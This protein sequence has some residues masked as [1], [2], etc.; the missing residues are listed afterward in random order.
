MD[1]RNLIDSIVADLHDNEKWMPTE[2]AVSEASII[3]KLNE[4]DNLEQKDKNGR[5]LLVNAVCYE[6]K[7]VVKYLLSKNVDVN[8]HVDRGFTAL[9]LAAETG[10]F[11]IAELLLKNGAEVDS[12]DM[13][14]ATPLMRCKHSAPLSIFRLLASYGADPQIKNFHGICALDIFGAYPQIIEIFKR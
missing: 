9:H 1:T 11:D 5:T 8:V 13:F 14:G 4:I 7:N 10:N 6:R 3:S 12:M 2:H